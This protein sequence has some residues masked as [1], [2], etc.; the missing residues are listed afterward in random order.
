[1]FMMDK[2]GVDDCVT[3]VRKDLLDGTLLFAASI[4]QHR[5]RC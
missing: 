3:G 1:M 5:L 2:K 4:L